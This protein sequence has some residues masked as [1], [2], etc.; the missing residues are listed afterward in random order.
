ML[1][2]IFCDDMN[3]FSY[4]FFFSFTGDHLLRQTMHFDQA[5]SPR[6]LPPGI[7]NGRLPAPDVHS[8]SNDQ[9]LACLLL[10]LLL[11]CV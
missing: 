4:G 9:N 6:L 8:L 5:E 1:F 3:D 7:F 10:C 2:P 11:S